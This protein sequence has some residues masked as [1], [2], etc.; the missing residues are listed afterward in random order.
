MLMSC[1]QTY[2]KWKNKS[3]DIIAR[4]MEL[5][6]SAEMLRIKGPAFLNVVCEEEVKTKDM[7]VSWLPIWQLQSHSSVKREMKEADKHIAAYGH[8]VAYQDSQPVTVYCITNWAIA[9]ADRGEKHRNWV[10]EVPLNSILTGM[11]Q[12][13]FNGA[14]WGTVN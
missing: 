1:K 9:Y 11:T 13:S 2:L 7:T 14:T 5:S 6:K 10:S 3:V 8:L 4:D 12:L